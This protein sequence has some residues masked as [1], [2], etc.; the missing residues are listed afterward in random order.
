VCG[1]AVS[2][3]HFNIFPDEG[4]RNWW[5]YG[6]YNSGIWWEL[7][8]RLTV[9]AYR[10][11]C[12][13]GKLIWQG[14]AGEKSGDTGQGGKS[15]CCMNPKTP[16]NAPV[17]G[18]PHGPPH[19]PPDTGKDVAGIKDVDVN[20]RNDKHKAVAVFK[21]GVKSSC[22]EYITCDG[23]NTGPE[24]AYNTGHYETRTSPTAMRT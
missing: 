13:K 19:G 3:T 8:C 23:A 24:P 12:G 7:S 6:G 20:K 1:V 17:D 22:G 21:R 15:Y 4:S 14:V 18:P 2:L 9:N 16:N 10:D 5:K 11:Y